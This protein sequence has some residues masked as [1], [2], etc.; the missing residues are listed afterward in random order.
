MQIQVSLGSLISDWTTL[1][2]IQ[3]IFTNIDFSLALWNLE[4]LS[5]DFSVIVQDEFLFWGGLVMHSSVFIL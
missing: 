3:L 2:K 4:S 1:K 5:V